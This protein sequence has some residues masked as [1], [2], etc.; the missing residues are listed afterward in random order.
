MPKLNERL[1]AMRGVALAVAMIVVSACATTSPSAKTKQASQ[2]TKLE[3]SPDGGGFT[4]TEGI[5]VGNDVRAQYDAA[6]RLLEQQQYEQGIAKLN[7]VI[8]SAP[9]A[10]A[11]YI[12]L[13]IAYARSGALDDAEANLKK[14]L[15]INPNHPV[16]YNEL[17]MIYRRKGKFAE[18]RI[19]YAKA[20]ELFPTFHYAQR[21][22]AI[23]CDIYLADFD[24]ALEHYQSYGKAAPGDE[25]TPKWIA[26]LNNRA[27]R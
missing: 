21:N 25:Q 14:A 2:A 5:V 1:P 27:K 24:C 11:A 6:L 13:G 9:E 26:D 17:G 3:I 18:A 19:S 8:E 15:Q 10:T 23:L 12:D 20:L 22:L 4:I 16:P 7:K